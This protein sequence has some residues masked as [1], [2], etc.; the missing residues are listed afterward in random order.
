MALR[1]LST[2]IMLALAAGGFFSGVLS[3]ANP[4]DPFGIAF[5]A[6]SGVVWFGWEMIQDA[7]AYGEER[8]RV[9]FGTPDPIL[10][11]LGPLLSV[12]TRH[13]RLPK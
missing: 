13:K 5:L 4:L 7:F 3:P 1:I 9:G 2:A 8:R 10:V 11:R 12:L 6:L